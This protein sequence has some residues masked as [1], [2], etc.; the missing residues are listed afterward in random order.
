MDWS[1]PR[2]WAEVPGS[3][4]A[5][6]VE[7]FTKSADGMP[8]LH[9]LG[10]VMGWR[11]GDINAHWGGP[12]PVS[13]MLIGA[14]LGSLGGYG[15]GRIGEKLLPERYF[16]PGAARKRLAILGAALGVAPG[17]WQAYDN[18]T[19]SG[20]R[21]GSIF[22]SWPHKSS[23]DGLFEPVINRGPFNAAVMNDPNTPWPLRAATAG[24]VEG[25]AAVRGTDYVS[26]WDVA[27]VAM[28]AG[29][30]LVSGV[31]V[32]KALGLLAGLNQ[33]GQEKIQDIGLWAGVLRNT[34]PQSLG[35]RW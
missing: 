24:L 4:R 27:R 18:Y 15:V 22:E 13:S 29:S 8:V 23:A 21:P 30:G 10:D 5:A 28:G 35:L 25:A 33:S 31:L 7:P 19:Q 9:S 34:V 17:A 3:V 16:T 12:R 1:P 26:P 11:A 14:A 6:L 2:T 32:G 20:G